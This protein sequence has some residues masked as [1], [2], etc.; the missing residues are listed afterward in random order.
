MFAR[1]DLIPKQTTFVNAAED[2]HITKLCFSAARPFLT[3]G[4]VAPTNTQATPLVDSAIG[5]GI[6]GLPTTTNMFDFV[7]NYQ[8]A[9]TGAQYLSSANNT[10]LCSRQSLGN[11]DRGRFL[12]FADPQ[13]LAA[14]DA[15]T[16]TVRPTM[17]SVPTL[18]AAL[19]TVTLSIFM[20]GYR[21]GRM[22]VPAYEI[23]RDARSSGA[24]RNP[25]DP[26]RDGGAR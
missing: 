2:F 16:F 1:G 11:K 5:L 13:Y 12:E 6:A 24:P 7:W 15:I 18:E 9:S 23:G 17:Y 21:T 19:C 8:I 4:G 20:I 25:G 22:A 26:R 10:F 3:T 14:G